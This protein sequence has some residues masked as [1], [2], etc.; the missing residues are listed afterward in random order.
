MPSNTTGVPERRICFVGLSEDYFS[1]SNNKSFSKLSLIF[2]FE[3]VAWWATFHWG[4]DRFG[5][6]SQWRS[7]GHIYGGDKER[8]KRAVNG[9]PGAC[10]REH[11]L[12]LRPSERRKTP[13]FGRPYIYIY[14]YM[15]NLCGLNA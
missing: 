10:P 9:G 7:Q 11:V 5:A 1:F 14:I 8:A 12:E 3:P 15:R 13:L 2:G 6:P 4:A